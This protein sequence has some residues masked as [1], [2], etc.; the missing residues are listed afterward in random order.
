MPIPCTTAA[1]VLVQTTGADDLAVIGASVEE[2]ELTRLLSVSPV[3]RVRNQHGRLL[4]LRFD[5]DQE[6]LVAEPVPHYLSQF[7][8]FGLL[9]VQLPEG[10]V[11]E[12]WFKNT[13][14]SFELPGPDAYASGWPLLTVFI[15][16]ADT[17]LRQNEGGHR[18]QVYIGAV[19]DHADLSSD[20]WP[21]VLSFLARARGSLA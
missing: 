18:F 3:L 16:Y 10:F 6:T 11:D 5:M 7:P 2:E 9:D 20:D 15:D 12:S 17:M 21:E 19:S 14:P 8:D 1:H 4:D 13:C